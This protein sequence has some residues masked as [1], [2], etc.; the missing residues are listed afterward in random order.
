MKKSTGETEELD[1][2]L[3]EVLSKAD[4]NHMRVHLSNNGTACLLLSSRAGHFAKVI[5]DWNC[6]LLSYDMHSIDLP[7]YP[8][9]DIKPACYHHDK[10]REYFESHGYPQIVLNP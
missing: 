3:K 8:S 4:W 5:L 10:R 7:K 9:V 6:K 1:A 2:N